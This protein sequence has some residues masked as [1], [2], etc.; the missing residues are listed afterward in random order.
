[1]KAHG[2]P[3]VGFTRLDLANWLVSRDNPLTARVTVNRIWQRY[4]G[5]GLVETEN[6]FGAQSKPPSHPELLDWLAAEFMESGWDVKALHRLIVSSATYRQSSNQR[7]ELAAVDPHNRLLGRQARLR[8]EA[9]TVRDVLLGTSGLLSTKIGGPSVFP[10]QPP[11]VMETRRSPIPWVMSA[12]ADRHRRGMYTH[13][14][15]TSPNPFLMTFDA[16]PS[17]SSCTRRHR[18]NTPLQAL[19][20]LNDPMFVECARGLAERT[21]KESSPNDTDRTRYVLRLC[22]AREPTGHETGVVNQLLTQQRSEFRND[23]DA[24]RKLVGASIPVGSELI[25]R[26]AWT[27]VA[28]VLLNLDEVITRE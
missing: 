13:F 12:G 8:L 16:P 17:D 21:L 27:A 10:Y 1:M 15:R 14:W 20:L 3:S 6:D 22:L 7:K 9:E 5:V 18:S 26:A 19:M 24:A 4:F 2:R 25:D 23:V 28:R 11:G